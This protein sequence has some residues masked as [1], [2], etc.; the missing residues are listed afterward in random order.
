M[1]SARFGALC[2]LFIAALLVPPSIA[3]AAPAGPAIAK[4][5]KLG[6]VALKR[7]CQRQNQANRLAFNQIKDSEF[8]GVRGDGEGIESVYCA[9]GRYESRTTGSYGTGVSTG[10]RWQVENAV[11]RQGGKWVDAFI[12]A[13]GGFEVALQRR[14]AQWLYGVASLG[15]ILYPGNVTK[16]DAAQ[17]CSTL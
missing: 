10:K 2:C 13:P 16:T 17:V 1:K 9:N 6:T 14:G 11:V 4:C 7:A 5:G 3:S 15:R 8:V 12:A